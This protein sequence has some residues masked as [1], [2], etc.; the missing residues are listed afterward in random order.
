VHR[1][2]VLEDLS[3]SLDNELDASLVRLPAV[4]AFNLVDWELIDSDMV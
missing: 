4:D 2:W 3:F 1:V